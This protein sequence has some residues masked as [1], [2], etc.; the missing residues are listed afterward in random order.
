MSPREFDDSKG[1]QKSK[2][3]KSEQKYITKEH[4]IAPDEALSAIA[5]HYYGHATPPYYN[6][7]FEANKDVIG[8]SANDTRPGMVIKI[9][10]LPDN[11]KD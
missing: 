8:E 6:L 9:P 5:L 2:A 7:I 1:P 3:G 10:V 4:T 11:M